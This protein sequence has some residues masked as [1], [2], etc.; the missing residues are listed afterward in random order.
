MRACRD[1]RG[2]GFAGFVLRLIGGQF[3]LLLLH[4]FHISFCVLPFPRFRYTYLCWSPWR[5]RISMRTPRM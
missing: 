1:V 4:D 5:R 2:F 3:I